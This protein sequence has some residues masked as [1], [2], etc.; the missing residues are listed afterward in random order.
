VPITASI[1]W[2][3]APMATP[4]SLDP[5]SP[6]ASMKGD[7]VAFRVP[8]LEA[9]KRWFVEKLDFRVLDQWTSEDPP[10]RLAYLAPA[11]NDLFYIELI[12]DGSCQPKPHYTNLS[13]SLRQGGYHHFCLNVA[14]LD[15]TIAELRRR[16]VTMV[17]GAFEVEAINRRLAFFSDPWGNLIELA[18]IIEKR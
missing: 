17:K 10:L 16:G 4:P 5:Q 6:F 18:Q 15:N 12:G 1:N 8:D 7:H 9:R 2:N 3:T 11:N 13:D 14:N